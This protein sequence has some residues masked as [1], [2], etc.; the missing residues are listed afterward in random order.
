MIQFVPLF[1]SFHVCCG[2]WCCINV[3]IYAI[4]VRYTIYLPGLYVKAICSN[5]NHKISLRE[6]VT[7]TFCTLSLPNSLSLVWCAPIINLEFS[8]GFHYL[9]VFDTKF[10][11]VTN[12]LVDRDVIISDC[13]VSPFLVVVTTHCE[14]HGFL[15]KK[16]S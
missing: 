13:G 4:S 6:H 15:M 7:N 2:V 12:T 3:D 9:S 11:T 16:K 10:C 14:F 5:P 8:W 1:A